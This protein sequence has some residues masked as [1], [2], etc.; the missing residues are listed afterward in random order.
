M[1]VKLTIQG[2]STRGRHTHP[3][4]GLSQCRTMRT[5]VAVI[6]NIVVYA[7]ISTSSIEFGG[8][9]NGG[10][11]GGSGGGVVVVVVVVVVM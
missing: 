8:G 10:G 6:C 5:T 7:L 1:W 9:R 3:H 11:V 4:S 2:T